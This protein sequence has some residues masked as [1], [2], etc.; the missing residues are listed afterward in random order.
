LVEIF[1]SDFKLSAELILSFPGSNRA[2]ATALVRGSED[3]EGPSPTTEFQRWLV[4]QY[5]QQE[6]RNEVTFML[7]I[8]ILAS[9]LFF[10][11]P[12]PVIG[13]CSDRRVSLVAG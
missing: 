7:S 10:L 6:L 12:F 2:F 8:A 11:R 13:C 3:E 4:E 1:A 9:T 5:E